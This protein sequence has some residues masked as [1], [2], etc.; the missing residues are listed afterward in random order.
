MPGAPETNRRAFFGWRIVG[1]AIVTG[2]LTGPG[3]TIGVSVFV[4]PFIDHLGLSRSSVSTAYLIGTM[5]AALGLPIV[6]TQIDRLGA[7]RSMIAIGAAFGAALV[8]MSGVQGFTTLV[9]GFV[10]IRLLGQGSLS[11]VST[12][13][14]TH[15]FERRRGTAM[16]I[17]STGMRVLMS[18]VPVGLSIVIVAHGWRWAWVVAGV[19]VWAVVVPIARFGI[20]DRP[21]DVGLVPDGPFAATDDGEDSPVPVMSATR[22]EALRTARFWVLL[23]S[24]MSI[25]M[26]STAL[27]FHQISLLGD[28][29]LTPVE[30]AVMFL[31][32][33]V[34]TAI[35]GV[36]FGYL[37][38]RL[39]G[40][41]LIPMVM[42]LLAGALLLASSLSPG[43]VIVLYAICLGAAGGA[44]SAVSATLLPR[45][46]GLRHIGAIQGTAA[47]LMVASTS[48]GPVAF[49]IAR[50]AAGNYEGAAFWFT[51]MPIAAG[52]AAMFLK[53][54][55]VVGVDSP[56]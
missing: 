44:G 20:V 3:Q 22:R 43:L 51:L 28:A 4:D 53:S 11:L 21:S 13:S 45:W 7:R 5:V 46:F 50:D 9:V 25:G 30:A 35:A 40:R 6:G 47:F 16:G 49:S 17:L 14:V 2:A 38:D 56:K 36:V 48:L 52:V 34:G 12:I 1:L 54:A 23:S 39:T 18:L 10:A 19:V 15:W 27:N 31:P 55:R 41:I 32:Q 8:A 29:G 26:L 24:T 37:A 33:V 42:A